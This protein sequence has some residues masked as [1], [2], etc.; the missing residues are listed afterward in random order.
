MIIS[1]DFVWLHFPKCA[2]TAVEHALRTLLAGR[3]DVRFDPVDPSNVIWHH[4]VAKREKYDPSFTLGKRRV[5]CCFRRLPT[6]LLSRVHYEA[7]RGPNYRTVTR[8]M[9]LKGVV[10][11]HDGTATPANEYAKVFSSP[12][13]DNWLRVENLAEDLS[14]VFG[15]ENSAVQAA[16][17]PLNVTGFDYV[18]PLSLWFTAR[19]LAR[20]YAANPIWSRIERKVYGSLLVPD[21]PRFRPVARSLEL[22]RKRLSRIGR[23]ASSGASEDPAGA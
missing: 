3:P 9:L 4:T 11:E 8:D 18:K 21:R 20:L 2:G 12:R 17:R 14:A 13:V 6:W 16:L 10:Y 1:D 15:L 5:V 7:T 22:L 23:N 19:E